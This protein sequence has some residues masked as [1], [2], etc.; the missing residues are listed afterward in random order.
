MGCCGSSKSTTDD[1]LDLGSDPAA[2]SNLWIC[3]IEENAGE[4]DCDFLFQA[5]INADG[6]V[7]LSKDSLKIT[8]GRRVCI[9]QSVMY[10]VNDFVPDEIYDGK[11]DFKIHFGASTIQRPDAPNGWEVCFKGLT[12]WERKYKGKIVTSWWG[13]RN[14]VLLPYRDLTAAQKAKYPDLK[15]KYY[16]TQQYGNRM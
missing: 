11:L 9:F 2:L 16:R 13:E 7:L 14:V 12:H 3:D 6:N 5:D 4:G 8:E 10:D 15:A 1:E